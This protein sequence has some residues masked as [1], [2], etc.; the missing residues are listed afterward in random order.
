MVRHFLKKHMEMNVFVK[1]YIMELMELKNGLDVNYSATSYRAS[2]FNHHCMNYDVRN[3]TSYTMFTGVKSL[4][5][6]KDMYYA[7]SVSR[8]NPSLFILIAAFWSLESDKPQEHSIVRM[9][10]SFISGCFCPHWLQI[11]EDGYHWSTFMR[12]FPLS[13]SL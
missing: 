11:W 8:R 1:L 7:T 13:V 5:Y 4:A 9:V 3:T 2:C 6:R 10:R 12:S